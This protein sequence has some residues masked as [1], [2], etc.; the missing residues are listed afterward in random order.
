MAK[1][2]EI[3][4]IGTVLLERSR[5]AR[6]LIITIKPRIGVRVAV[7]FGVSFASAERFVHVKIGWIRRNLVKLEKL[8]RDHESLWRNKSEIDDTQARRLLIRR[9]EELANRH[10][11]TFNRVFIRKQKTRWGSCSAQ[12]NIN[13]NIKL[14]QLPSDLIDY[15]ILHELVHTRVKSH[16]P[17]FWA[18]LRKY[19]KNT[20]ETRIKLRGNNLNFF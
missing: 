9:L 4:G 16:Q 10:G 19:F 5:R 3:T 11:F 18:E 2:I 15:V 7:P 13:L 14:V 12:N 6:R 17:K 8:K 1:T 20:D